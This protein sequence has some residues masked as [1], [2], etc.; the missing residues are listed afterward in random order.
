M[1]YV[2]KRGTRSRR[3]MRRVC[4]LAVLASVVVCLL[5]TGCGPNTG[6]VRTSDQPNVILILTDDLDARLPGE[7]P[8]RPVLPQP[9]DR[10]QLAA[11]GWC[12][13]VPRPRARGLHGRYLA[14]RRGL[15]DGLGRQVHERLLR[16]SRAGRV[17][18][19]VRDSRRS[20]E[21]PPQRERPDPSLRSRALP[22]RRRAGREGGRLHPPLAGGRGALLYVGG[23]SGTARAGHVRRSPRRGLPRRPVAAAALLQ[24]GGRLR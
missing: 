13:E 18:R 19:L 6:V 22:P 23:Y 21:Y 3:R 11:S 24:R 20:P 1:E 17:G 14:A 5:G 4:R 2:I 12:R 10:R 9:P 7:H 15:P 16:G 8:A